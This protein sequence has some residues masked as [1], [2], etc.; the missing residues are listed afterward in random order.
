M[1]QR[2]E[3]L[4]KDL[5]RAQKELLE[6]KA[7]MDEL[8]QTN[9]DI[10]AKIVTSAERADIALEKVSQ[11]FM[12]LLS[13]LQNIPGTGGAQAG[14]IDKILG[15][16]E[17]SKRVGAGSSGKK[18][19]MEQRLELEKLIATLR[20]LLRIPHTPLSEMIGGP[21]DPT[22]ITDEQLNRAAAQR[23][24]ALLPKRKEEE[25]TGIGKFP[26]LTP[27]QIIQYNATL[28]PLIASLDQLGLKV[29]DTFVVK[30]KLAADGTWQLA[31]AITD[32]TG[33]AH[34]LNAVLT[35][36]GR[37]VDEFTYKQLQ[38]K[39]AFGGQ[40]SVTPITSLQQAFPAMPTEGLKSLNQMLQPSL[41][42]IGQLG[43]SL[44][45]LTP[46]VTEVDQQWSKV[47]MTL[48]TSLGKF[49]QVDAYLSK[50]GELLSKAAY[51]ARKFQEAMFTEKGLV[52]SLGAQRAQR[53]LALAGK[54]QIGP[55]G[56][57]F[58]VQHLK[59][60]RTEQPSGISFLK[61]QAKDAEN[62]VQRLEVVV[63]R[64][65]KVLTRTNR[66]LLG[67]FDSIVRNTGELIKWSVGIGLVYGTYYRFQELLKT[68]IE[69]QSKL[70]DTVI[71][72]GEAQRGVNEIFDDASKVAAH[73]GEAI[74]AV[75][76]TY[77]LA[78]RAVGG[79]EDPIKRTT[80][81][82]RLLTD[83]TILNKLSSLEASD[84]IDVLAGA[85]RQLQKP[86]EDVATAFQRG[87]ELLDKW[88]AVTR[89]ANVDL[90]T[91]ATAFSITAESAENAGASMEEINAIIAVISEKI[92]GLG[93]RETGNAVR[94]LIGGLYQ[95]QG[96]ELLSRYAIAVQDATGKMRPFLD[97]SQ[98]IYELYQTGI[99]DET[100]LNKIGFVLGGGVRRGQQYVAFLSDFARVQEVVN[101]QVDVGGSA[102]DA[103]NIKVAT[104]Q[105]SI[106]E[107]S[108]AFQTLAQTMGTD[109]G[110][111]DTMDGFLNI[112]TKIVE[113]SDK[114]VSTLGN[115]TV[116][117][118]LM[119]FSAMYFRGDIGKARVA[120]IGAKM[121]GLAEGATFGAM[122]RIPVAGVQQRAVGMGLGAGQ[123]A[124]KYGPSLALGAIPAISRFI[125]GDLVEGGVEMGGAV[126]GAILSG[127]HPFGALAGSAL[128]EAFISG[129]E[130]AE[131]RVADVL[132]D[133]FL[134]KVEDEQDV[135]DVLSKKEQIEKKIAEE[136]ADIFSYRIQSVFYNLIRGIPT[137]ETGK[138]LEFQRLEPGEQ[139]K[140]YQLKVAQ[141]RETVGAYE[142][143]QRIGIPEDVYED[144]KSFLQD[145]EE[146]A[147][148][149]PEDIP[150]EASEFARLQKEF[151][152]VFGET[153]AGITNQ[154]R[155]D[156]REQLLQREI[157]P[158]EYKSG[159]ET[160]Q[161]LPSALSRIFI[162]VNESQEETIVLTEENIDKIEEWSDVLISATAEDKEALN[163]LI[164]EF[165]DLDK[166]L[167]TIKGKA[168][169]AWFEY[170]GEMYQAVTLNEMW[171]DSAAG[172]IVT[173]DAITDAQEKQRLDAIQ[174]PGVTGL[175]GYD[176]SEYNKIVEAARK[177]QS[178]RLEYFEGEEIG[179]EV[180][181]AETA[182]ALVAKADPIF[183]YLGELLG[184][185][186][187]EGVL[188]TEFLKLA[189][190]QLLEEGAITKEGKGAGVGFQSFDMSSGQFMAQIMGG[191]YQAMLAKLEAAGYTP[192]ISTLVPIFSDGIKDA[193]A[194]DWKIVQ[195]L[196][197]QI[198]DVEKKQLDGIYN[199]PAEGTFW[200]P[201]QTLEMARNLG[202][203]EAVE[204]MGG[205]GGGL[206]GLLGGLP[207]EEEPIEY[208]AEAIDIL[209]KPQWMQ[210]LIESGG[211]DVSVMG[212]LPTPDDY[213][214]Q[215]A[216]NTARTAD[217]TSILQNWNIADFTR[218]FE[219]MTDPQSV[220]SGVIP[221]EIPWDINDF[222]L[223][224]QED[225]TSVDASTGELM[226]KD[227]ALIMEVSSI[228]SLIQTV[229]GTR[230]TGGGGMFGTMDM[231]TDM[232][233]QTF[234]PSAPTDNRPI[235]TDLNIDINSQ[236]QLVVDGRTLADIVK[237][238][239]YHDLIRWEGTSGAVNTTV[240]V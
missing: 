37:I 28:K 152:E 77:T 66:R 169:D 68:A 224:P 33:K 135:E 63:D 199:L 145:V 166:F 134:K 129:L 141:A 173:L 151:S 84:S 240:T 25:V 130:K 76:E 149:V 165:S 81:A 20:E 56:E 164:S 26:G 156:I 201:Q 110:A 227:S 186:L 32:E 218:D 45:K 112:L 73:T 180:F 144:A 23:T 49:A 160:V 44:E 158:K 174:L 137:L 159:L 72:L 113:F 192:D 170:N 215:T 70:A 92:G 123:L 221:E 65:G 202:Y 163:S 67:F 176:E 225:V 234:A 232:Q 17:I 212:E 107:L 120:S 161:G 103:L 11:Q 88:V 131:G 101:S 82:N 39:G 139:L 185:R 91:L 138:G 126:I 48:E 175:E 34:N 109:G 69:N 203:N 210:D 154:A 187:T 222:L 178:A 5:D 94:A 7:R 231:G 42:K 1:A 183:I 167:E 51:E 208:G 207:E 204:A 57:G 214:R 74:N 50:T 43:L 233:N 87:T 239:L 219:G 106:T 205:G 153:L 206:G 132:V 216:E 136:S 30:H 114:A 115:L 140:D 150:F 128:V 61:F 125:K 143:G 235:Q 83:A 40:K 80:S 53:A 157:S 19:I 85:L 54:T 96:A 38:A 6:T 200:V 47:S 24:G 59:E 18:M 13:F 8:A 22:Q 193:M 213:D 62:V 197:Q 9:P 16:E 116:P 117:A 105:T 189:E 191:Q 238:Y 21:I 162:A 226:V 196:L 60:V 36:S 90:A 78:Y 229:F 188:S 52:G 35:Q 190:E 184:Y 10:F 179:G 71:S 104:L 108:N 55:G 79:I 172:I 64:F 168:D 89:R 181:D 31:T 4:I 102:Q 220:S 58:G 12:E 97:V 95:Q 217:N 230:G 211:L 198:L 75:L 133:P 194:L 146:L 209:Q 228:R 29:E 119:A 171:S 3:D 41:Q 237:P 118:A 46:R 148:Y 98:D 147:S 142:A 93:G 100:Q 182:D 86:E 195:Y 127:G 14:L 177:L 99:I 124:S 122:S 2:L 111:L 223:Q 155:D 15:G 121:G 236:I 27:D